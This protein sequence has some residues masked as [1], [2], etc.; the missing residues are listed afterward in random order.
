[1]I[2]HSIM[3]VVVHYTVLSRFIYCLLCTYEDDLFYNMIMIFLVEFGRAKSHK[4]DKALH[5]QKRSYK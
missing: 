5:L 2:Q 4:I 3:A 1:M